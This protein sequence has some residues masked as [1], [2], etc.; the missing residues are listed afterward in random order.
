MAIFEEASFSVFYT[1]IYTLRLIESL[2]ALMLGESVE[3][4]NRSLYIKSAELVGTSL[5]INYNRF[6]NVIFV[7]AFWKTGDPEVTGKA[8]YL[9]LCWK[10]SRVHNFGYREMIITSFVKID[11][12]SREMV[13]YH[14][15]QRTNLNMSLDVPYYYKI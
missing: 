10:R 13:I 6:Y 11:F 12:L 8:T 2:T 7:T 5:G 14:N 4:R 15:S 9:Q 1:C 3:I